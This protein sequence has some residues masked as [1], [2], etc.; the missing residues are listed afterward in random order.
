MSLRRRSPL[1]LQT[2]AK[3]SLVKASYHDLNY[4]L[5]LAD[6]LPTLFKNDVK[7][8]M[9]AGSLLQNPSTETLHLL[10]EVLEKCL[11]DFKTL[12]KFEIEFLK[13]KSKDP[14]KIVNIM[15]DLRKDVDFNLVVNDVDNIFDIDA[16][17]CQFIFL[18]ITDVVILNNLLALA[19]LHGEI[20]HIDR[21]V[22]QGADDFTTA[23]KLAA[24][25]NN[26]EI[27]LYLDSQQP[28][29]KCTQLYK[30]T[31]SYK[32]YYTAV[33]ES[34]VEEEDEVNQFLNFLH[35]EGLITKM[36]PRDSFSSYI[37]SLNVPICLWGEDNLLASCCFSSWSRVMGLVRAI[38]PS[39]PTFT[40]TP[41][42]TPNAESPN[43]FSIFLY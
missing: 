31:L 33:S 42:Q 1:T 29:Y 2:L 34:N 23:Q 25:G 19:S 41:P 9:K 18:H 35:L 30:N 38:H 8:I 11:T 13:L 5:K 15:Y 22:L 4:W 28:S 16:N 37:H 36:S 3:M 10:Y 24:L 21:L 39:P 26:L 43:T 12:R 14:T 27:A 17:V 20:L 7:V 32:R 6:I 40:P